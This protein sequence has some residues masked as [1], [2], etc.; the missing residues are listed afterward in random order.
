[1]LKVYTLNLIL[2]T[3]TVIPHSLLKPYLFSTAIPNGN[4]FRFG[5]DY[6]ND[7]YLNTKIYAKNTP[8]K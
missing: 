4:S 2:F 1:M 8:K 5:S 6:N 3:L 7:T